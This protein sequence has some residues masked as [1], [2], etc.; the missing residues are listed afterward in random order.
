MKASYRHGSVFHPEPF[1]AVKIS[2]EPMEVEFSSPCLSDVE[3]EVE[4]IDDPAYE[5]DR[6]CLAPPDNAES[7][8]TNAYGALPD[9]HLAADTAANRNLFRSRASL[10]LGRKCQ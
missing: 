9:W 8:A 7:C 6:E 4:H 5:V 1:F 10:Y 3:V 2:E